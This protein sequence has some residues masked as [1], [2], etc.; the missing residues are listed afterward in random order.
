MSLR[1]QG[2]AAKLPNIPQMIFMLTPQVLS[3]TFS[4]ISPACWDSISTNMG[5]SD[6]LHEY[7]LSLAEDILT[8]R[9]SSS[10]N[11]S[12]SRGNLSTFVTG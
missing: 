8:Q 9:K 10:V 2:L 11:I 1:V 3:T 5:H 6:T 12:L 4:N 7:S